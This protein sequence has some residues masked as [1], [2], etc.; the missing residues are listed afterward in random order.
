MASSLA[1]W[2]KLLAA[3]VCLDLSVLM[4]SMRRR[5]LGGV[6]VVAVALNTKGVATVCYGVVLSPGGVMLFSGVVVLSS[7]GTDGCSEVEIDVDMTLNVS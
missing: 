2:G 6:V 4:G 5:V 7:G 3:V 1:L